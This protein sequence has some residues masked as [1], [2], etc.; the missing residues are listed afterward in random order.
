MALDLNQKLKIAT[1]QSLAL[2]NATIGRFE[3]MEEMGV[4]LIPQVL[5]LK[6][7]RSEIMK[8]LDLS[9]ELKG[10]SDKDRVLGVGML[11]ELERKVNIAVDDIMTLNIDEKRAIAR[12]AMRHHNVDE[13]SIEAIILKINHLFD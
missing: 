8:Y 12:K 4:L 2:A 5:A 13:D 1:I 10:I 11:I 9:L 6:N 3:D 7:A